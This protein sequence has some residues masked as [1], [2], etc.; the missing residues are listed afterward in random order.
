MYIERKA[1]NLTGT[2][3]I[4]RV[5][6]S[7]TGRTLYYRGKSFQSLNGAGFK[8]NYYDLATGEEYWISGCKKDGTDR[9]YGER[10]PVVIDADVREEYWT[11]IRQLPEKKHEI[12]A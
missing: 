3:R 8:S 10:V 11:E 6:F 2:A 5:T 4:G 7:K 1:G 12:F 9:L